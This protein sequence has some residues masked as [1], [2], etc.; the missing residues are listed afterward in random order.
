[1][2]Q[3]LAGNWPES[4]FE[5][6]L[7]LPPYQGGGKLETGDGRNLPRISVISRPGRVSWPGLLAATPSDPGPGQAV[8]A[9]W[10]I[11][12]LDESRGPCSEEAAPALSEA[13]AGFGKSQIDL[14]RA[15]AGGWSPND[16]D[17][18]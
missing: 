17:E 10:P 18:D 3:A 2:T 6:L 14:I 4:H 12:D 11:R 8:S 7:P 16:H 15:L 5:H 1:M 13:D 9:S